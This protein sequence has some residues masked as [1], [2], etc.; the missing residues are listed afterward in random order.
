MPDIFFER[1][2]VNLEALDAALR[3]SLSEKVFGV[4]A[5]RGMVIVHLDST[6]TPDDIA[7]VRTLV[8]NHNPALLTPQQQA[9]QQRRQQLQQARIDNATPL[10]PTDY[11]GE[12]NLI[13]DLAAKIA[14]LEQEINTLNNL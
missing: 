4:S 13:R 1:T 5:R 3:T 10:D 12:P 2:Q 9:D 14:W 7:Q 11:S 6:A 8:N